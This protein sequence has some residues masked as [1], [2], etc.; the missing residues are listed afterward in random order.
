MNEKEDLQLPKDKMRLCPI[1]RM[2]IS[3]W[4]IRCRFCGETVGR[5]KKEMETFTIKD[6]G[7]ETPAE[8]SLV[9]QDV[10]EAIEEF[11]RELLDTP[12]EEPPPSIW[13]LWRKKESQ[14]DKSTS[15][16]HSS[17]QREKVFDPLKI[18]LAISALVTLCILTYFIV[19]IAINRIKVLFLQQPSY[20]NVENKAMILLEKNAPWKTVI[21]EALNACEIAPTEENKRILSEVRNRFIVYVNT[22]LTNPIYDPAHYGE[23]SRVVSEVMKID[24]DPQIQELYRKVMEEISA[25]KMTVTQIDYQNKKAVLHLSNPTFGLKEQ[26]VTE[27]DIVQ[28][29]FLV[30]QILPSRVRLED[31]KVVIDGKPRKLSVALLGELKSDI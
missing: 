28:D 27:G 11:R 31:K 8:G 21:E 7:G 23:A 30:V 10:L 25:Y 5:P 3:V 20:P 1:C 2:P 24:Y 13:N 15:L 18:I 14:V 19:P 22:L 12:H 29:R 26:I 9:S 4:A 16:S 17:H 6:L